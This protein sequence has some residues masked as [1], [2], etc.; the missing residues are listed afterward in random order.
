[1]KNNPFSVLWTACCFLLLF[2]SFT[3]YGQGRKKPKTSHFLWLAKGQKVPRLLA[4]SPAFA[5]QQGYVS[6]PNLGKLFFKPVT[7][8]KE[9][10]EQLNE[11]KDL[12]S[13]GVKVFMESGFG[14]GRIPLLSNEIR[15]AI[16]TECKL[17]NL[18]L[19]IH[20]STEED[21]AMALDMEPLAL[22]HGSSISSNAV[23]ERLKQ[24]PVYLMSTLSIQDGFTVEFNKDRLS[25]PFFTNSVPE[26]ELQSANEK[27]AWQNLRLR[28]AKMIVTDKG[29][30]EEVAN[31]TKPKSPS[32]AAIATW[33]KNIKKLHAAGIPIVMG[34]DSGNWPVMP[35]AFHGPTSIREIEL[36]TL[37]GLT[38]LE[39]IRA[40]TS[41]P[42]KMLEIVQH[43]GSIE[44]GK[45]A[46]L[47]IVE[48]TPQ[49]D[50]K[51]LKNI[52]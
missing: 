12:K 34:S 47:V 25:D 6:D 22:V 29:T 8:P 10:I 7:S 24:K 27:S 9:V 43:I 38:P 2:A 13:K 48:G 1:M 49:D 23:L 37:S 52:K 5:A 26:I 20:S 3:A 18:P 28:F 36:L 41:L 21:H 46:D 15:Q 40:S 51:A 14:M 17:R 50:I 45:I 39:A 16:R 44:E 33:M 35:Q 32:T 4:L 42:A 31:L 19:Y 30:D 11:T